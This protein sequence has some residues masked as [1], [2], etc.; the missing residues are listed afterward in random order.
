MLMFLLFYTIFAFV[1]NEKKNIVQQSWK[2]IE[3][4]SLKSLSEG[5]KGRLEF[6]ECS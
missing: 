4:P 2:F 5:R 1:L 6:F 3:L